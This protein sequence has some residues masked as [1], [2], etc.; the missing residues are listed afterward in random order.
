MR[1]FKGKV[2]LPSMITYIREKIHKWP[3]DNGNNIIVQEDEGVRSLYFATSDVQSSMR[4]SDHFKLELGYTRTMMGFLLFI[5]DP[6][7]ILNIL[8]VGLGGG[9]LSKYCYRQFP[10]AHITTLEINQEVIELRDNFLIP[11]DDERFLVVHTDAA[12]YLDGDNIH[13]DVI[14]LDGFDSEGLPENLRSES[15]YAN[16][17]RALSPRGVLVANFLK[18]N[19]QVGV[20]V[21]RLNSVFK[22]QVWF[23]K[24][25]ESTNLIAF[26]IKDQSYSPHRPVVAMKAHQMESDYHLNLPGVLKNMH[27]RTKLTAIRN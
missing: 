3:P 23:A 12:D 17:W 14:L 13:A 26:G 18:S 5:D 16:C 15:F 8:I 9:S 6:N 21:D 4:L 10:K 24:A 27:R 2:S 19:R 25:F 1:G 22:N 7:N 11:S 20:Y